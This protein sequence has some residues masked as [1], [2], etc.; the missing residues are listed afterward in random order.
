MPKRVTLKEVASHAQVSYQTVSK[1]LNGQ[2]QVSKETE[3]RIWEAVRA[4]GYHPD[5]KARNLRM[6]R[7]GMIGYSWAPPP[8][9][10]PNSILD[11]FLRSMMEA[12]ERAGYH[13]LP[14]PY[15]DPQNPIEGYR[16]LIRT[17]RVDG[18][19]LSSVEF[20]DPRI[21]FLREQGFGFVAFGRPNSSWDVP[22]VEVDGAAGLRMATEHLIKLGHRKIA[23]LAWPE[24]SRV[25]RDR[26][27]GYLS[28]LTG[29]GIEPRDEWIERGVWRVASGWE[30]THRL[31]RLD[32]GNRPTAI[33]AVSDAMAI[34]A[35]RAAQERGF[36][37]GTDIAITGFDDAPMVQYLSPPLTSVRQPIWEVGQQIVSILVGLLNNRPPAERQ[38]LL[39]PRL[40]VRASSDPTAAAGDAQDPARLP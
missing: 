24:S 15:H 17:G 5:F 35:M 11:Q 29:A 31:L 36:R 32:S 2:S 7:S 18:F 16:E 3:A 8:P 13:V 19:V 1:V 22:Y 4:L 10:Q 28:A 27:G 21:A 39:P 25:G 20:D 30:G 12:T 14:F 40:I 38:V 26:L 34:G 23:A 37:V 9:D 6:Q 33:V